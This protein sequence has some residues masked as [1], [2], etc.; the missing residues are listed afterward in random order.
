M[1][2]EIWNNTWQDEQKK[3]IE[4]NLEIKDKFLNKTKHKDKVPEII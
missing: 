4:L 3:R 1:V 2:R